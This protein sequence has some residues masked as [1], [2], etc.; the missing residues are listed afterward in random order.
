MFKVFWGDNRL[1]VEKAAKRV[2]GANYEIFE[3]ENLAVTDL[4]SIFRGTSLFS[5]EKRRILL[6]DVSENSAV[7]EKIADY[8]DTDHTVIVWETKIDKRSVA[9]KNLKAKG[10]EMQEFL[11]RQP[12][13]AKAVFNILDT[14][15]RDGSQA[16][17]MV[18]QIEENQDPYMFFGL[19]VT[20]ALK[21]FELKQGKKEQELLKKLGKLDIQMKTSTLE[22]WDLVK[23]FL[24]QID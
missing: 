3:G 23:A 12:P 19:M 22:A 16:V 18:E 10:V 7:W 21:K 20:Q 24:L 1:E 14:A 6:K 2:L 9:Y 13:E 5:D 11:L 17:R 4:P 15:L 8:I